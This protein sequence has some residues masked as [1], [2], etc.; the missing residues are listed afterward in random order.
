MKANAAL[1]LFLLLL[2]LSAA[3]CLWCLDTLGLGNSKP[4]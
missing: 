1:L 2:Y 3:L 4:A